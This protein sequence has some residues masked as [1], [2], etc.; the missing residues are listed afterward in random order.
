MTLDE[1][2]ALDTG[3]V[4]RKGVVG[5]LLPDWCAVGTIPIASGSLGVAGFFVIPDGIQVSVPPDTCQV[6]VRLISFDGNFEIASARAWTGN[7]PPAQVCPKLGEI[8]VDLAHVVFA[9]FAS[10]AAAAGSPDELYEQRDEAP[11]SDPAGI[12]AVKIGSQAFPFACCLSGFGDGT[13]AV[14]GLAANGTTVGLEVRFLADGH[15]FDQ[16]V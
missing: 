12:D 4:P 14:F 16:D 1:A 9:D 6:E 2:I 5:R 15:V 8:G 11:I 3:A 7:A 10:V 13:Y